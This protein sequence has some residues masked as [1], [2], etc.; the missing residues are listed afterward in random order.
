MTNKALAV[1]AIAAALALTTAACGSTASSAPKAKAGAGHA[2]HAMHTHGHAMTESAPFGSD[3]GMVPANGM[4]SFH[5]MTMD[6]VV[7]AAAH[8]PLLSAFAADVKTAGLT[9]ELNSMR[10]FTVFA[11]ANAAFGKL[12]AHAMAML[13]SAAELAR[14]IKYGVV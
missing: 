12:P 5:S 11:P 6:P 1:S 10:T 7:T 9:A 8:N 4:G 3:C 14:I 2:L 13:H